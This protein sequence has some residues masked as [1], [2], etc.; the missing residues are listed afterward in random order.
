MTG[1]SPSVRRRRS[2]SWR[3]QR[4]TPLLAGAE[5]AALV[6]S[7]ARWL[8][9]LTG[10]VQVVV[11]CH[12]VDL[13]AHA[14]RASERAG[15]LSSPTLRD[16]ALAHAAFLLDLAEDRDPL[17]RRVTITCTATAPASPNAGRVPALGPPQRTHRARQHGDRA[18]GVAA[19]STDGAGPDRPRGARRRPG[20]RRR[21]LAADRVRRSIRSR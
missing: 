18:G 13:G 15:R 3:R 4:S 21:N 6:A 12:R 2:R 1:R 8:N 11:S 19:R 10:P 7:Y 14:L 16:A 20:R 5:Q 17:S 9:S